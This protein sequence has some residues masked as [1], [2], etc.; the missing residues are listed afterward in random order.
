MVTHCRKGLNFDMHMQIASYVA[1]VSCSKWHRYV[2]LMYAVIG[3]KLSQQYTTIWGSY[4]WKIPEKWPFPASTTH[5][6]H[7][8][9]IYPLWMGCMMDV[10]MIYAFIPNYC[11]WKTPH[12]PIHLALVIQ[13]GPVPHIPSPLPHNWSNHIS[14]TLTPQDIL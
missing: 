12:N 9:P 6:T 5:K 10:M 13:C 7:F 3:H 4:T 14:F 2:I 1:A 11:G 8:W